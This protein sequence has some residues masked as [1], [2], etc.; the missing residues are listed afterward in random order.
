MKLSFEEMQDQE[1]LCK[2]C[3]PT[4]YGEKSFIVTPNGY[5]A[6]EGTWCK[7]AYDD[8]LESEDEEEVEN[9]LRYYLNQIKIAMAE[10]TEAQAQLQPMPF[11]PTYIVTAVKL[12]T[13]AI[14]LAVNNTNIAEKIDYILGDSLYAIECCQIFMLVNINFCYTGTITYFT[15][16]TFQ[17]WMH[18]FTRTAPSSKEIN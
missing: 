12:P 11:V 13:G 18:G 6:C 4:E 10:P 17:Y 14:E 3:A 2:Y 7:E 15:F 9:E 1:R 5:N 8:Y 16:E